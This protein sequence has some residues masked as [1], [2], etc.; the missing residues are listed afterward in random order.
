M[1]TIWLHLVLAHAQPV[2]PNPG[3]DGTAPTEVPNDLEALSWTFLGT[4]LAAAGVPIDCDDTVLTAS[5]DGGTFA[6]A[7]AYYDNVDGVDVHHALRTEVSELQP[8]VR[9]KVVFDAAVVRHWGQSDG[10]WLVLLGEEILAGPILAAPST[11]P[12]QSDWETVEVFPFTATTEVATLAFAAVTV[13]NGATTSP[14]LPGGTCD[15]SSDPNATGLLLDGVRMYGDG[16]DDLLFDDEEALEG[17]DPEVADTDGDGLLD[18]AEVRRHGSDPRESDTDGDGL[19][20]GDEITW[21]T[22][23]RDP[24]SDDDGLSDGDEVHVHGTEP[25]DADTDGDGIL[26]GTEVENGTLP[27]DACSPAP[28]DGLNGEGEPC[29]VNTPR[30]G[31]D[32]PKDPG[33]QC[34][35]GPVPVGSALSGLIGLLVVRRRRRHT[36]SQAVHPMRGGPV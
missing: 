2:V 15:Y 27:D 35:G 13:S 23:L 18:G 32:A 25:L 34:S 14:A 11:N 12:G 10:R 21:G 9:Y 33:C 22:G 5:P 19:L 36:P 28:A 31:S 29:P 26:D 3:L 7:V 4:D 30:A 6:H 8:G 1:P 16:D 24:D 17:T 20:D